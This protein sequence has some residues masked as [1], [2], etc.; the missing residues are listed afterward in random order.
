MAITSTTSNIGLSIPGANHPDY[1]STA[2][3]ALAQLLIGLANSFD[4]YLGNVQV[5]SA[6]GAIT[7]TKGV[8]MITAASAIAV[9][10]PNGWP[11]KRWW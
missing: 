1:D 6:A 5:V 9:T 7:I 10:L 3:G 8:V 11:S 2:S 4:A